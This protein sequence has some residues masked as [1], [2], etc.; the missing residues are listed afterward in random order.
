[1]IRLKNNDVSRSCMILQ[2]TARCDRKRLDCPRPLSFFPGL[3]LFFSHSF[4]FPS[5]C[6][7]SCSCFMLFS[8][9][10]LLAASPPKRAKR[11]REQR[12]RSSHQKNPAPR[13]GTAC[14]TKMTLH[15][16]H[17]SLKR[18]LCEEE[19][20]WE[21]DPVLR[22]EL[23]ATAEKPIPL[24]LPT[25]AEEMEVMIGTEDEDAIE[26]EITRVVECSNWRFFSFELGKEG[27]IWIDFGRG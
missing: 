3:F 6:I 22:W 17:L 2:T 7:S 10:L 21:E 14:D 5:S 1:M 13:K 19:S 24:R 9:L 26:E 12:D 20:F 8:F 25:E 27:I 15:S 23:A 4:A 18:R 16:C 11:V